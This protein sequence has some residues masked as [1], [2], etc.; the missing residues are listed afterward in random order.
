[1]DLGLYWREGDALVDEL[2]IFKY[3]GRPLEQ[4]EYD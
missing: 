2:K 1:M 3:L 4:T